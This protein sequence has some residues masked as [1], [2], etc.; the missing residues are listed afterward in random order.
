M[1][2]AQGGTSTTGAGRIYLLGVGEL[3]LLL[4]FAAPEVAIASHDWA[5]FRL[6]TRTRSG[7]E[8]KKKKQVIFCSADKLVE[9]DR[10]VEHTSEQG[11]QHFGVEIPLTGRSILVMSNQLD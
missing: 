5:G 4:A 1:V 11:C 8:R 10:V 6:G 7:R 2:S 9:L 3:L